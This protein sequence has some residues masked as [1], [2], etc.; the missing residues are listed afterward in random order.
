MLPH[1]LQVVAGGEG[2]PLA[3]DHHHADLLVR[4]DLVERCL[5]RVDQ[6][7]GESVGLIR[8]VEAERGDAVPVVAEQRSGR[9]GGAGLHR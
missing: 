7:L 9:I 5:Q 4:R 2:A 6:L 1:L 3:R 8:A